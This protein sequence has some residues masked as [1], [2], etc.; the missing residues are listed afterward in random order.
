[1][2]NHHKAAALISK[3]HKDPKIKENYMPIFLKKVYAKLLNKIFVD[4]I[5][6]HIKKIYHNQVD[7]TLY[8][9]E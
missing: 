9:Q 2:I 4:K 3:G 6:G 1:M 5:W 8:I 7:A